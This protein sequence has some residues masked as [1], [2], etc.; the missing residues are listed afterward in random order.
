MFAFL[1]K[2]YQSTRSD[3]VGRL[4]GGMSLLA[5]GGTADPAYWKEWEECVQRVQSGNLS[6]GDIQLRLK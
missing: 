6:E 4:L 1:D 2:Y 5:D 3:E